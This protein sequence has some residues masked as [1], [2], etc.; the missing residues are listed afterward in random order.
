MN[1]N[2]HSN[3]DPNG[4]ESANRDKK[5]DSPATTPQAD[6]ISK[7]KENETLPNNDSISSAPAP[8][9]PNFF[10]P[11]SRPTVSKPEVKREE[12]F[13]SIF[14]NPR[15][16]DSPIPT[17]EPSN[18]VTDDNCDNDCM[19]I[20][21]DDTPE[22]VKLRWSGKE[23]KLS[24]I[25]KEPDETVGLSVDY[26]DPPHKQSNHPGQPRDS[27]QSFNIS[28]NR[29]NTSLRAMLNKKI[30]AARANSSATSSSS[31]SIVPRKLQSDSSSSKK[32]SSLP[33]HHHEGQWAPDDPEKV[34]ASMRDAEDDHSWMEKAEFEDGA[35]DEYDK[36]VRLRDL[37][38]KR[39]K[40]GKINDHEK[41]DLIRVQKRLVSTTYFWNIFSKYVTSHE[42]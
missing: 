18:N 23:P 35:D 3:M 22:A 37:L 24:R 4:Q 2:I 11:L 36:L 34:D 6:D 28:R 13:P 9:R 30:Q 26:Q 12:V 14:G 1:S 5:S 20:N 41:A 32:P 31:G 38:E 29:Q 27:H 33:G 17:V 42:I 39:Q 21:I 25:K 7:V 19:I 40:S 8:S 16:N 15:C 10:N